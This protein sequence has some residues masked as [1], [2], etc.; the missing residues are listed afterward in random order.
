MSCSRRRSRRA[1]LPLRH[2]LDLVVGGHHRNWRVTL[3]LDEL[4]GA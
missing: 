3:K 4:L 2:E 1:V